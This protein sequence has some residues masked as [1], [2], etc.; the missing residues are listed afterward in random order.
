M[1]T[2]KYCNPKLVETVQGREELDPDKQ[3]GLL[4]NKLLKLVCSDEFIVTMLFAGRALFPIKKLPIPISPTKVELDVIEQE[5]VDGL[6]VTNPELLK[7]V[8]ETVAVT[9]KLAAYMG[10]VTLSVRL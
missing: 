8:P 9:G 7:E 6:I 5:I 3:L 1:L 2:V 10:F 4:V